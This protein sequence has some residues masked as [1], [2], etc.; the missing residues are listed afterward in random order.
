MKLMWRQCEPSWSRRVSNSHRHARRPASGRFARSCKASTC[1]PRR[2]RSKKKTA[3][4]IEPP[5]GVQGA[6]MVETTGREIE[7]E[8]AAVLDEGR[9]GGRQAAA[10]AARSDEPARW[11]QSIDRR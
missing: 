1:K 3:C 2:E 9:G 4:P 10:L 7:V 8:L 5:A 6:G 11:T